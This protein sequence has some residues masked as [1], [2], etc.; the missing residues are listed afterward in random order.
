MIFPGSTAP[1]IWRNIQPTSSRTITEVPDGFPAL[2][3]WKFRLASLGT[4]LVTWTTLGLLFGALTERSLRTRSA[5]AA[6]PT[7]TA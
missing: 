6:R 1:S 5:P 4:Q 2:V 3:L 7:V